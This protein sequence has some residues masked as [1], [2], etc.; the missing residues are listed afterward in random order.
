[1]KILSLC[2][3]ALSIF[4]GRPAEAGAMRFGSQDYLHKIQ[5]IE[6]KGKSDEELFL[7]HRTT[8]IWFVMGV[9]LIDQG[10]IL[11]AKGKESYYDLT[12]EFI[13]SLQTEKILPTPLPKYSIDIVDYLF[14]YSLWIFIVCAVVYMA[15]K[16]YFKRKKTAQSE[17]A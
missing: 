11:G 4:L 8:I 16:S 7:G 17:S 10:Y 1:M 9:H 14:G 5:D 3:A 6:L 15:L 13:E 12:P 2:I